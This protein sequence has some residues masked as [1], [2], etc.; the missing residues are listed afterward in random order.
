[1]RRFWVIVRSSSRSEPDQIKSAGQGLG[2]GDRL[3]ASVIISMPPLKLPSENG[4]VMSTE[5]TFSLM[6]DQ[7]SD[8]KGLPAHFYT[9]GENW[10]LH[11]VRDRDWSV[12]PIAFKLQNQQAWSGC[13]CMRVFL[14]FPLVDEHL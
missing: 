7:G 1:M 10:K 2:E 4:T 14:H 8:L 3:G 5:Q 6:F 9:L 11:N 12:G 13:Q